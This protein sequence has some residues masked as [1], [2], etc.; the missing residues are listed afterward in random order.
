VALVLVVVCGFVL[1]LGWRKRRAKA[2]SAV[3]VLLITALLF[4]AGVR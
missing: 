3:A 1:S 2:A 4:L